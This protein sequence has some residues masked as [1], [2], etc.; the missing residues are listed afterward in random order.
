MAGHFLSEPQGKR[1]AIL[2]GTL[3]ISKSQWR[4]VVS[5][6]VSGVGDV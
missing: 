5:E 3:G 1:L 4:G 2:D 6:A